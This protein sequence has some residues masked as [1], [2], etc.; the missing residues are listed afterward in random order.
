M[1]RFLYEKNIDIM[2]LLET[3]F[4]RKSYFFYRALDCTNEPD[5]KVPGRSAELF[6]NRLYHHVTTQ[7]QAATIS[8]LPTAIY[9]LLLFKITGSQFQVY[10]S[11]LGHTYVPF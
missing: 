7:L 8:L 4:T 11:I 2:L 5:E 6:T 1:I 9:C 10:V 3:H